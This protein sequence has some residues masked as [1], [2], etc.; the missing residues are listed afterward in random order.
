MMGADEHVVVGY[1]STPHQGYVKFFSKYAGGLLY[2]FG[3]DII[4][5]FPSLIRNLPG[6][7]PQDLQKMI[8]ALNIFSDVRILSRENIGELEGL[9]IVMPDED[10]SQAIAERY[11]SA[12][13]VLFDGSWKLRWD[14]A[15]TLNSKRPKEDGL[16]SCSDID[17]MLMGKAYEAS[18]RSSDWWRQVGALLA[19]EGEVLLVAFNKHQPSEQ[20]PY[21]NGDPRSNFEPG[22]C[23]ELSTALHAE[24]GIA[25]TAARNG[26]STK[27]CDLYVTTFPCP[28]CANMCGHLGLRRLFFVEGYS[29]VE[30]AETLKEKGVEIIRVEMEIPSS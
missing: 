20:S 1:V 4:Q 5:E 14:K 22:Q 15:S 6:N 23:I 25:A 26:L 21:L 7:T 10:V 30:G 3:E 28:P 17:R 2:I 11:F 27:G 13:S 9:S 29:L 16:V 8:T 24:I 19:K 18:S 12:N